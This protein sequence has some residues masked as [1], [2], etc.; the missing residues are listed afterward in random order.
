MLYKFVLCF[1]LQNCVTTL[2]YSSYDSFTLC[3]QYNKLRYAVTQTGR[4]KI[5]KHFKLV[6]NEYKALDY[7]KQ[8]AVKGIYFFPF[9]FPGPACLQYNIAVQYNMI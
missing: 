3:S 6:E 9:Y 2:V 4:G 8:E 5:K 1:V 7:L